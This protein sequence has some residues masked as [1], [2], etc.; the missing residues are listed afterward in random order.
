MKPPS[1]KESFL[2]K[3]WKKFLIKK[4]KNAR[5]VIGHI[6]GQNKAADTSLEPEE[7]LLL[8]NILRLRDITVT[9][10]MT[11][12]VDIE[13]IPVTI[14]YDELAKVISKTTRSRLPVYGETLD[15]M[16]GCLLTKDF[17]KAQKKDFHCRD[18]LT[19]VLYIPQSTKVL[20]LLVRMK[21]TQ[22]V[23]AFVVDEFGG[24]DGL[25][26][27]WDIFR[28]ILGDLDNLSLNGTIPS[29]SHLSDHSILVDG[30]CSLN[31]LNIE[32]DGLFTKADIIDH[33]T[34]SGYV[35]ALAGRVPSVHELIEHSSG[36]QFEVIDA[37]ARR[38]KQV[39]IYRPKQ[40]LVHAE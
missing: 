22:I 18:L 15:E 21:S 30:R 26:T 25:V 34:I 3:I 23:M 40:T 33:D 11:P 24:I 37:D 39:R 1:N 27:S 31:D 28:E 14:S 36:L 4:D 19:Q 12:R 20:D 35:M 32:L 5:Q 13:A 6:I 7:K 10:I 29:I 38:I 8:A 9:D 16:L 17:V 2:Q